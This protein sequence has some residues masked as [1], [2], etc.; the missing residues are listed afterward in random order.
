MAKKLNCSCPK[1]IWKLVQVYLKFRIITAS[2]EIYTLSS[3]KLYNV[4]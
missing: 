1:V 3:G 2:Q 4:R